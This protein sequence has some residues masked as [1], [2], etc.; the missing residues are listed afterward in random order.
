MCYTKSFKEVQSEYP[1][2][3][4]ATPRSAIRINASFWK[5]TGVFGLDID[6]K[7][8]NAEEGEAAMRRAQ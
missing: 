7:D 4:R 1:A 8:M 2:L 6:L 5:H 3:I